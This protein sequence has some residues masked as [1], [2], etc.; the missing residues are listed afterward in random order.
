M[1]KSEDIKLV[2][3]SFKLHPIDDEDII[4]YLKGKPKTYLIKL[5]LRHLIQIEENAPVRQA[6]I[7]GERQKQSAEL[8]KGL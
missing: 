3:I 4:E 8:L 5:G 6:I 1:S 2:P 7:Q